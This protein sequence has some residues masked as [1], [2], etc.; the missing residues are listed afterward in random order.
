[1]LAGSV[2]TSAPPASATTTPVITS[3]D[4]ATFETGVAD[5]FTVTATGPTPLT[6]SEYGDLPDGVTFDAGTGVLS[7]TPAAGSAGVYQ[8]QFFASTAV[9]GI[10]QLFTLTVI[11]PTY[12]VAVERDDGA[13]SV[14]A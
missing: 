11:A 14:Q 7:G 12:A 1:M 2:L 4:L 5:S 9:N 13:L 3:A 10:G 8:I 6:L